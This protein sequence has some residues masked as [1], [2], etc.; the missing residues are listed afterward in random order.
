M[1]VLT[2]QHVSTVWLRR[3]SKTTRLG[4][5]RSLRLVQLTWF[6]CNSCARHGLPQA[7]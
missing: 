7:Y 3:P 2:L 6:L 1:Y 5:I 4:V